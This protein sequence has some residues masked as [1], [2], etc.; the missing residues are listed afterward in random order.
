MVSMT[1]QVT[2]VVLSVSHVLAIID[3]VEFSLAIS[4]LP[5]VSCTNVLI[6]T[7]VSTNQRSVV[8]RVVLTDQHLGEGSAT[9]HGE[10]S[11]A[12]SPFANNRI[13]GDD[14]S[15]DK[16][17]CEPSEVCDAALALPKALHCCSVFIAHI[18]GEKVSHVAISVLMQVIVLE[19]V[20]LDLHLSHPGAAGDLADTAEVAHR[21]K[22]VQH[23]SISFSI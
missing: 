22:P 21:P 23:F 1:V 7:E 18:V 19:A 2:K 4:D 5:C 8:P 6:L 10:T 20:I 17:A 13:H 9:N 11:P 12:E 14:S 16:K 15:T 3:L